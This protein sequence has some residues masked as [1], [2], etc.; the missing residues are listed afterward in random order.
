MKISILLIIILEQLHYSCETL[1]NKFL[2]HNYYQALSNNNIYADDLKPKLHIYSREINYNSLLLLM[3]IEPKING[4]EIV[5][6]N[7]NY[8]NKIT[9]KELVKIEKNEDSSKRLIVELKNL[10]RDTPYKICINAKLVYSSNSS[11][12]RS[13]RLPSANT[14]VYYSIGNCIDNVITRRNMSIQALSSSIGAIIT[15]VAIMSCIYLLQTFSSKK[16]IHRFQLNTS[17]RSLSKSEYVI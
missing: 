3:F 11:L 8:L 1:K 14:N 4:L 5:E 13:K 17:N 15:L 7:V 6:Y 12:Y 10:N 9:N 2:V 16:T